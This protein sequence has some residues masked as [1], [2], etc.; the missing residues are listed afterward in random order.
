MRFGF[1]LGTLTMVAAF[2]ACGMS[3]NDDRG[4][5]NQNGPSP[6]SSNPG[7]GQDTD[8]GPPGA[9]SGDPDGSAED[10]DGGGEPPEV[11]DE[12]IPT[13]GEPITVKDADYDKWVW[14]D[15]PTM[16]CGD[17]SPAGVGVRFTKRSRNLV[18]WFQGNGACYD[19]VSCYASRDMLVGMGNTPEKKLKHLFWDGGD[20]NQAGLFDSNDPQNPFRDDNFVVLPHCSVDGHSAD[21]DSDYIVQK[22]YQHGYRNATEALKRIVPTFQDATRIVI[23]GFSAGGIGTSANYHKFAKAFE[24][25]GHDPPFMINDSGPLLRKPYLGDGAIQTLGKNWGHADTIYKWCAS[26]QTKGYNESYRRIAQLHPGV[27]IAQISAYD[28]SVSA[29]LYSA[30]NLSPGGFTNMKPGLLDLAKWFQSYETTY[31]PSK[32]RVYLY[33]GT[34]HGIISRGPLKNHPDFLKFLNDQLSG[35]PD[36]ADIVK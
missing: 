24:S 7:T 34:D 25:L 15:V 1:I 26:C 13:F 29:G 16:V 21:K 9:P 23:A 10:P 4:P 30:L 17:N 20:N 19:A 31:A 8:G 28:D 12:P 27:R 36:W 33:P 35:S 18:V 6:S 32:T 2:V 11:D 22:P 5:S 3:S 14:V